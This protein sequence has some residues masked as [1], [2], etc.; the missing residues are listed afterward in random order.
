MDNQSPIN[1]SDEEREQLEQLACELDEL[2]PNS[3]KLS[4]LREIAW[5]YRQLGES[6]SQNLEDLAMMYEAILEHGT[7]LENEL[8]DKNDTISQLVDKMRRYLP[9]QLYQRIVGGEASADVGNHQRKYLT[10]FFSD[11]VGFTDITDTIEPEALSSL[12]NSYLNE[13]AEIVHRWGGVLDKFIGDAVM[14]FF[15]DEDDNDPRESARKCVGMALDMQ[16]SIG[17]LRQEWA[18]QGINFPLQMRIGINSGYCTVGNFGSEARLD[19]TIIGGNVNVASRL[20]GQCQP[21]GLLISGSTYLHVRD[22]VEAESRGSIKVK[23]VS[24]PVECYHILGAKQPDQQLN[25]SL[26]EEGENGFRLAN[27]DFELGGT[28]DIE[29]QAIKSSLRRALEWLDKR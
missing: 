16:A 5:H 28:S 24:H 25:N 11:I 27:I 1:L 22:M 10:V 21:G 29:R 4:R 14:V 18:R 13:M 7:A 20:E 19:Y 8:S 9:T 26:L 23:G 2:G 17:K 15:G 3:R 12:L 6:L